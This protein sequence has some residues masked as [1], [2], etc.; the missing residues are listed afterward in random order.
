MWASCKDNHTMLNGMIWIA[1]SGVP[2]RD[3]PE[4]YGS[5]ESVYNRFRKWIED[6]ILDNLFRILSMDVELEE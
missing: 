5:W 3:L 6:D 2:Q 4:H 1:K